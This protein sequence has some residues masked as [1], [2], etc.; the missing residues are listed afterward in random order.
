MCFTPVS[1]PFTFMICLVTDGESHLYWSWKAFSWPYFSFVFCCCF[2]FSFFWDNS[3][4]VSS[5]GCP[6]LSE[7]RITWNSPRSTGLYLLNAGIKGTHHQACCCFFWDSAFLWLTV[8]E[9]IMSVG[10]ALNSQRS[11]LP[12]PRAG[13]SSPHFLTQHHT[14]LHRCR[15]WSIPLTWR[16]FEPWWGTEVQGL[17]AGETRE[18]GGPGKDVGWMP[19]KAKG[20]QLYEMAEAEPHLRGISN[21][22]WKRCHT[23]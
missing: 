14:S 21:Q 12:L 9:L 4:S 10:L 2:I 6:A 5:W 7:T 18:C 1:V 23:S 17:C 8:L 11:P 19:H 20:Q 13:L 15:D 3:F 22:T 16:C